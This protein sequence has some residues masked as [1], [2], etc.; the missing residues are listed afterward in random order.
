MF[1]KDDNY[2]NELN[3]NFLEASIDL[4]IAGSS[5]PVYIPQNINSISVT[6]QASGGATVSVFTTTDS[7]AVVRSGSGVTWIEWSASD[8]TTPESAVFYPVTAIKSIQT[9]AGASKVTLRAQ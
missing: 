4:E 8:V 2:L 7:I 1:L 6:A 9:G 3:N 5:A